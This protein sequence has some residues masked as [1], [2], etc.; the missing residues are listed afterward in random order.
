MDFFAAFFAPL[1]L[2]IAGPTGGG[3]DEH[4]GDRAEQTFSPAPASASGQAAS[5]AA[6]AA[7]GLLSPILPQSSQL[8]EDATSTPPAGT[9]R[10]KLPPLLG[11]GSGI[12]GDRYNQVRIE[13]R[14]IVRIG[15]Q[16]SAA[17][18][19]LSANL[20]NDTGEAQ[21]SEA[22][23]GKCVAA[24][25]ILAVRA[26][27]GSRLLLFLRENGLIMASLDKTCS[28]RDFYSGFYFE[29]NSDGQLCIDR[30][31]LQSRSG[32]KCQLVQLRRLV[33]LN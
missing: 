11:F 16:S 25:D 4:D 32:A 5:S 20:V 7:E 22:A 19:N 8:R 13:Q 9:N 10:Q 24:K 28:S 6:P 1:V 12:R 18:R 3:S 30:E 2:L 31:R 15:P 27:E 21:Y 29:Q 23:M 33:P 14:V 26:T 17:S